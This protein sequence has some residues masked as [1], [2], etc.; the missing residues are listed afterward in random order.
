MALMKRWLLHVLFW[1]AY[2]L[3]DALM[4]YTW[5][6]ALMA[7]V[8]DG[9]RFIIAL[10]AA[11]AA[12]M[13]KLIITYFVL[14]AAVPQVL[15]E[16]RNLA[17]VTLQVIAVMAVSLVLYR[18]TFVYYINQVVYDGIGK[19]GALFSLPRLLLG[20]IDIGFVCA[21]AVAFKLLRMQL[22]ARVREKDLVKEKLETELKF[23]RNQTNPHF[24]F[25]TLNNIYALTR[26]KSDQAPEIVMKLS[27]LL[28]FMLYESGK[29]MI[30]MAEEIRMI[31]DYLDLE[32]IRYNNRL[33]VTFTQDIDQEQHPV[34]PLLL[35]PFVENAFKHGVS[36]TRFDSY[37][38]MDLRLQKG[39]L[40]FTVE[41][42]R[43]HEGNNSQHKIGLGNVRRQLEL[44]YTEHQLLVFSEA[45]V[46]KVVLTINLDSHAKI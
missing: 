9:R 26:K 23:L 28:R 22:S 27:K 2:T 38:H 15:K 24:L 35:M 19:P 39:I 46:F 10:H 5:S 33:N 16:K 4:E 13:P 21:T 34:A 42:N 8:P 17:W 37:V 41:N 1:V 18:V 31:N 14:Y 25:N 45:A 3:Q 12:T 7:G 44:M 40:T 29:G 43:E 32:R 36:E 11:T 6:A 20:I 30:T